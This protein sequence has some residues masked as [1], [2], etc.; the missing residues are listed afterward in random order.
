MERI[1]SNEAVRYS[2]DVISMLSRVAGNGSIIETAQKLK[3][4]NAIF[5][6]MRKAFGVPYH[7]NLSGDTEVNSQEMCRAYGGEL[8][9]FITK[10]IT[11]QER[12]GNRSQ[13]CQFWREVPV[14]CVL[15]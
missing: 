13:N 12:R 10:N 6:G 2:K 5:Q 11:D 3:D 4:V 9:I 8:G 15:T 14:S 7:G 1:S